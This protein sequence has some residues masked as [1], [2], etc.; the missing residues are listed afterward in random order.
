MIVLAVE[1]ATDVAGVALA[2][3]GGVLAEVKSAPGRRHAESIAP[4]LAAVC[5]QAEV[6][7]SAVNAV[8]VDVGPGLFTGLRVG[9]AT[10][11]ALAFALDVPVA[12]VTSLEV[13]AHAAAAQ[14]AEEGE[15]ENERIV[16]PVVDARRGEV[17]AGRFRTRSAG[18]EPVGEP[19]RRTPEDLAHRLGADRTT[20]EAPVVLVGNGARRYEEL[21][22][23]VPGV[24]FGRRA[25]A[26]PPV[27]VLATLGLQRA[28]LGEVV[29]AASVLPVYLR[30]ADTRIKWERRARPAPAR[31]V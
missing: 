18:A 13:L 3:E 6:A 29:D 17:F 8:V 20:V 25:L 19:A 10:A 21:L 28:E 15:S 26:H 23:G 14:L 9:V 1:S 30:D 7:L 5:H 16:V 11:K 31:A 24:T 2:D 12:P 27:G 4:A 22:R